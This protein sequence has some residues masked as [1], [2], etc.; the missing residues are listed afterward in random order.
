[1]FWVGAHRS[2]WQYLLNKPI[3]L[4]VLYA[5]LYSLE[6]FKGQK[7][8]AEPL[9]GS[10]ILPEQVDVEHPPILAELVFQ[11]LGFESFGGE[12]AAKVIFDFIIFDCE[13]VGVELDSV[14]CLYKLICKEP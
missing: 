12:A 7:A 5:F 10:E 13:H 4:R 8:V 2:K 6:T 1:M 11:I 14:T 3:H 9:A